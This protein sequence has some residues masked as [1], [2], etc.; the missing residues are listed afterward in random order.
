MSDSEL[1]ISVA[2]IWALDFLAV[3]ALMPER[4]TKTLERSN[5]LKEKE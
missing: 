2:I 1:F 4:I 3:I 5:E